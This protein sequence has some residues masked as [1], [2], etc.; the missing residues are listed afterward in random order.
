[1]NLT[2][3]QSEALKSAVKGLKDMV[4]SEHL[5][6]I[7]IYPDGSGELGVLNVDSTPLCCLSSFQ[8]GVTFDIDDPDFT[9]D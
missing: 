8:C 3:E 1:M 9:G 2:P 5:V 4:S 6:A 7:Y